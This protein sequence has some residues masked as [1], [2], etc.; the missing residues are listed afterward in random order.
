MSARSRPRTGRS[1]PRPMDSRLKVRAQ[2]LE[3]TS[4]GLNARCTAPVPYTGDSST[5]I[6]VILE[7]PGVDE[8]ESGVAGDKVLARELA[9]VGI[10]DVWWIYAV[11]CLPLH[12]GRP[13]IPTSQELNACLPNLRAQLKE[14]RAE[15]VLLAGSVPLRL[16][17]TDRC[18]ALD[19][20]EP[21]WK[22]SGRMFFPVYNPRATERNPAWLAEL[23]ADL[24]VFK[25]LVDASRSSLRL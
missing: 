16:V 25:E 10:T 14:S 7:A 24:A 6:A 23:R 21:F 2:V 9:E 1:W 22:P 12:E 3:C 11:A 4:C 15:F 5:S 19:H 18:V 13:R 17:R 20:G 8:D